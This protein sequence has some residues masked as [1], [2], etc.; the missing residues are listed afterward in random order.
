MDLDLHMALDLANNKKT[1]LTDSQRL[2]RSPL[3]MFS[4]DAQHL[5]PRLSPRDPTESRRAHARA[6]LDTARL[7]WSDSPLLGGASSTLTARLLEIALDRECLN[8]MR[9]RCSAFKRVSCAHSASVGPPDD[10]RSCN[11]V[12]LV[13]AAPEHIVSAWGDSAL[14]VAS[15]DTHTRVV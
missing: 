8:S 7:K 11:H 3:L 4:G 2:R 12:V 1:T 9:R 13:R 6:H 5:Q 15:F 14:P 10:F